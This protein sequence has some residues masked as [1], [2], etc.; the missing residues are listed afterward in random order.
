TLTLVIAVLLVFSAALGLLFRSLLSAGSAQPV[1]R[2]W[3]DEFSI[4]KYRPMQRLLSERDYEFLAMQSGFTPDIAR[5]LRAER[6][7]IFRAYLRSLV[8]DFNRISAAA[9]ELVAHAPEDHSEL[10]GQLLRYQVMFA[11]GV[12]AVEV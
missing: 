12:A 11:I 9:R 10:A 6:R 2:S 8:R 3:L 5:R 7:K 1:D 4:A